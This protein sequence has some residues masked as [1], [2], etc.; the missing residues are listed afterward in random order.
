[1]TVTILINHLHFCHRSIEL[2]QLHLPRRYVHVTITISFLNI[3]V[4]DILAKFSQSLLSSIL[5]VGL[6]ARQFMW[7]LI[8]LKKTCPNIR[9]RFFPR[10]GSSYDNEAREFNFYKLIIIN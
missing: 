2:D 1:M 8:I 3:N 6:F 10:H 7:G 4:D 5:L 9:D